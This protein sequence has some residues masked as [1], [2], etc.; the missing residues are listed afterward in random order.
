MSG[1]IYQSSDAFGNVQVYFGSG[2]REVRFGVIA[3]FV[4]DRLRLVESERRR[5]LVFEP[6]FTGPCRS[7]LLLPYW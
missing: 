5:S 4:R 3:L 1:V 7:R 2:A 6:L